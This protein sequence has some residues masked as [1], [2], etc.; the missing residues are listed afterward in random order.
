MIQFLYPLWFLALPLTALPWLWPM[1]Q[2]RFQS[3][4][5][6]GAYFLLPPES[7]RRQLRP[8]TDD[9][10]LKLLRSLLILLLVLLLAHPFWRE[11]RQV[12]DVWVL[13]DS[14][15]LPDGVSLPL[16]AGVSGQATRLSDLLE[17]ASRTP[18]VTVGSFAGHP[19]SP[20]LA[21]IAEAVL[22]QAEGEQPVEY[23]IHLV[24]DFQ[25]SQYQYYPSA[26]QPVQ[27]DLQRPQAPERSNGALQRLR[28]ETRGFQQSV[29]HLELAG[30]PTGP[31]RIVVQQAGEELAVQD[32]PDLAQVTSV[33]LPLGDAF[34]RNQP[35]EARLEMRGDALAADDTRVFLRNRQQTPWVGVV[36]FEG[37][38]GMFRYGLHALRS[39]LNADELY[40][41]LLG[42]AEEPRAEE[43]DA[44]LL[45]GDHPIRAEAFAGFPLRLFFPTRLGDWQTW[46]QRPADAPESSDALTEEA[47]PR[48]QWQVDWTQ[49]PLA[50]EWGIVRD[51]SGLFYAEARDLWLAPTGFGEEWG[52]FYQEQRFPDEVKRW[53]DLLLRQH[54]VTLA[55]TFESGSPQL[56]ALLSDSPFLLPGSYEVPE[57]SGERTLRFAVNVPVRESNLT[58][59]SDEEFAAMQEYLE[60]AGQQLTAESRSVSNDL[61]ELLLWMLLLLAGVE[62][63][64]AFWRLKHPVS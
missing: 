8:S 41:Y 1:V 60:R 58:L 12:Q 64:W 7:L 17:T 32:L 13:D 4:L 47:L 15:S 35:L 27:W 19:G 33:E 49:T 5:R 39:A 36:N 46:A 42:D 9:W 50:Q 24:S 38:S 52:P 14:A 43:V 6:F 62:L 23:Q 10:L 54:P 20:S 2:H 56:R 59:M 48:E 21:E 44:L 57:A 11:Q 30:N 40:S 34:Q 61:R 45:L 3:P 16:D 29:L 26:I 25:K 18:N 28:L 31:G 51:P 63:T 55:G 22:R 37:E 53:L